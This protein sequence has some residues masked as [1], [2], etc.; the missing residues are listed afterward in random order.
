MEKLNKIL[1]L[2][3][4]K[5]KKKALIILIMICIM[6]LL[7]AIG[8]ASVMPFLA[9]VAKP[10]IINSNNILVKFQNILGVTNSR[11]YIVILGLLSFL[12]LM[13]SL[14]FQAITTHAMLKF[15]LTREYSIGKRLFGA[16]INQPYVWY[17]NKNSS[18]LAKNI[19]S[20]VKEVVDRALMPGMIL[21]AQLIVVISLVSLLLV[22]NTKL[23]IFVGVTLGLV[24]YFIFKIMNMHMSRIG[25][26]RAKNNEIRFKVVNETLASIKE[27]KFKN[28]E[29]VCSKRFDQPS[30]IYAN[31]QASVQVISQLPRFFLEAVAFGGMLLIILY[32]ME[33]QNDISE[34]LPTISL[35]AFVGYRLM[36]ALQQ[37]YAA[38]TQLK[39]A[40][41]AIDYLNDELH[42][43]K[44]GGKNEVDEAWS[45]TVAFNK[46]LVLNE[47]VFKYPNSKK[48]AINKVSLKIKS[49][50]TVAL[51]GKTGCGKTTL[52]DI[53]LGLLTPDLGFI[54]VDGNR[55]TANNVKDWQKMIGYVPQQIYLSDTTLASNI[56]FGVDV[57][58]IDMRKVI[59]ASKFANLHEYV[60]SSLPEKYETVVGERGIRL[61]GGQRQRIGIARALYENPKVIIMDEATSALDNLTEQAVMEAVQ[62]LGNN[63]TLII[64]AHRLSTIKASDNI[65][66]LEDGKIEEQGTYLELLEKSEKFKQMNNL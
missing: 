12:S 15:V 35:Y 8:V 32:L 25:E 53:I 28:L 24:Y 1:S 45:G 41:S 59:K 18:D 6:A 58:K 2:L 56:A 51:I 22:A 40:E 9:V 47:I 65:I 57:D 3:D 13:F 63:V 62:T 44:N 38:L 50:T 43:L 11:Q 33:N 19:T 7:N 16:Y 17:L 34:M 42:K 4:K 66:I 29:V 10:E 60:E 64:I 49:N 61:S 20:E 37:I 23:T 30:L 27:V 14:V 36:P 39:Y 48:Y 5:E 55:I 52:A 46:D 26:E 31:H 54:T 21:L